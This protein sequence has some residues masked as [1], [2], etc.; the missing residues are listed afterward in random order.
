MS[1]HPVNSPWHI[2]VFASYGERD[3]QEDDYGIVNFTTADGQPALLLLV[4]DGVGGEKGGEVASYLVKETLLK[5]IQNNS[6]VSHA[7]PV[8]ISQAFQ[9][10]NKRIY[11]EALQVPSRA[12]MATT[13][14]VAVI[15]DKYLYIA[16]VGDTRLYLVRNG[17]AHQLT[18]DHNFAEEAIAAGRDP[19]EAYS[20]PNRHVL[21]RYLGVGG[22]VEV[23]TRYRLP[24]EGRIVDSRIQP[25]P[26][27]EGD[28]LFL[29]S[30]GVTDVVSPEFIAQEISSLPPEESARSLVL[31]A[32][33]AGSQDNATAIVAEWAVNKKVRRVTHSAFLPYGVLAVG[34]ISLAAAVILGSHISS[35]APMEGERE[36][37][38]AMSSQLLEGPT[39]TPSIIPQG[40]ATLST[41]NI[42]VE[43][44][45]QT[46]SSEPQEVLP[47]ATLIPTSTP[48][49]SPTPRP[50][51]TRP[52]TPTLTPLPSPSPSMVSTNPSSNPPPGGTIY[53]DQLSTFKLSWQCA[54][55]LKANE[56]YLV[57]LRK[58]QK[59]SKELKSYAQ[60]P[61]ISIPPALGDERGEYFWEVRIVQQGSQ[62]SNEGV[63][64]LPQRNFWLLDRSSSGSGKSSTSHSKTDTD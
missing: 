29:C 51:S 6:I 18:I 15:L 34:M 36:V 64:C 25:L 11:E 54:V 28:S 2:G 17:V 5:T 40:V 21:K 39:I 55:P 24:G 61:S 37:L 48:T 1:L 9:L 58:S 42:H 43:A 50:M 19:V 63:V 12:G 27:Q 53:A 13:C 38:P 35:R 57:I 14:T 60:E 59:E 62:E 31:A 49:S 47:I 20:H 46:K 3:Y 10:A 44:S 52:P 30:D 26:L 32:V 4:A 41:Q 33:K 8:T 16:H 56:K 7:L 45:N 22:Q 23:D